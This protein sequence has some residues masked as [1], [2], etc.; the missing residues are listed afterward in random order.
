MVSLSYADTQVRR[1]APLVRRR[2]TWAIVLN[3]RLAL[4]LVLNAAL[5]SA[6]MKLLEAAS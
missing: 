1:G 6:V 2:N 4:V 3:W 5:W